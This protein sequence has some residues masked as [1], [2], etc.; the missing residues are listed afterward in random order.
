MGRRANAH[1]YLT[2][3]PLGY[4]ERLCNGR[5]ANRSNQI[6]N[7]V[8]AQPP[9]QRP[10]V[11][12]PLHAQVQPG[13]NTIL[14]LSAA[15]RAQDL[16]EA[17]GPIQRSVAFAIRVAL[18][19]ALLSALALGLFLVIMYGDEFGLALVL[20]A[21][22]AIGGYYW[23]NELDHVY[24]PAG[25]EKNKIEAIERVTLDKQKG[26]RAM[27]REL[28]RAYLRQIGAGDND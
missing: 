1:P 8:P 5:T 26:D 13:D 2:V 28:M 20:F 11:A 22:L 3:N 9:G 17:T 27:R 7:Y 10:T 19:V 16:H 24:S 25:I 21:G 12:Y 4:H 15:L 6:R 23:L 18:L 14:D